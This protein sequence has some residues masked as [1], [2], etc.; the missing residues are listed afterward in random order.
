MFL[1]YFQRRY[2]YK[3]RKKNQYANINNLKKECIINRGRHLNNIRYADDTVLIVDIEKKLQE[4]LHKV[5]K[6][7]GD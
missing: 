4:F 5:V 7:G 3:D 1:L 2:H 6:E